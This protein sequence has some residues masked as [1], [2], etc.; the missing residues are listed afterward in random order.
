M[1]FWLNFNQLSFV[2]HRLET[3]EAFS[4][5]ENMLLEMASEEMVI[6]V[7]VIPYVVTGATGAPAGT[8]F[9]MIWGKCDHMCEVATEHG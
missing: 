9:D 2:K 8:G 7:D 1:I 3:F 6:G 5:V 4:K